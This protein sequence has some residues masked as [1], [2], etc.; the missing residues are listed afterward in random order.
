[1]GREHV[2]GVKPLQGDE[3]CRLGAQTALPKGDGGEAQPKAFLELL[4]RKVPL[5]PDGYRHILLG[6]NGTIFGHPI[7]SNAFT[8]VG[9]QAHGLSSLSEELGDADVCT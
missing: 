5:W 6:G 7:G 8:A 4:G 3:A 9:N 1:M 2:Q